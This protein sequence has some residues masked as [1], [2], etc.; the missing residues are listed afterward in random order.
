MT[1]HEHRKIREVMTPDPS[2][3][4]PSTTVVETARLMREEDV[5]PIPIV[6]N[7]QCAGIVTDR[8]IVVRV[9]AEGRNA[10]TTTVGEI[11]SRE[12]ITIDPEQTLDEA[13][14]LMAQHQIRRLPVCEED[15]KLVGIVAQADLALEARD[16]TTGEVVEEISRK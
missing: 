8:D 15:G 14:R 3:V 7:G 13:A 9:V 16:E 11:A 2:T 4:E 10:N 12:L 1:H 5:G 6:E